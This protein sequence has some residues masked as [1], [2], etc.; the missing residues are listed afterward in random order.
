MPKEIRNLEF[1]P[2]DRAVFLHQSE[3]SLG[4]R[5]SWEPYTTGYK[6]LF[7]WAARLVRSGAWEGIPV[8]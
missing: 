2:F 3:L 1:A 4:G 7:R 8:L 5:P 6:Y